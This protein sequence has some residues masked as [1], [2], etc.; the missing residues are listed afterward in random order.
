MTKE[1]VEVSG[2]LALHSCYSTI[3]QMRLVFFIII[4]YS[5]APST[6]VTPWAYLTFLGLGIREGGL[7]S[8]WGGGG[9]I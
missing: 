5:A 4:I 9:H 2:L 8:S 1:K 6:T 7:I 3:A